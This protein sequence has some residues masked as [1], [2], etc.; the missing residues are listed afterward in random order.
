MTPKE[1]KIFLADWKQRRNSRIAHYQNNEADAAFVGQVIPGNIDGS[2]EPVTDGDEVPDQGHEVPEGEAVPTGQR[3]AGG[4]DSEPV[5]AKV[6]RNGQTES[7]HHISTNDT[8]KPVV[9]DVS[10]LSNLPENQKDSL[11]RLIRNNP[12]LISL[13]ARSLEGKVKLTA[14][15]AAGK[16]D[17]P[18]EV[19]LDDANNKDVLELGNKQ[20][21]ST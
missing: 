2:Y 18:V 15:R 4:D 9:I 6:N 17:G 16:V 11:L 3:K 5:K 19:T 12:K 20:W 10:E 14:F 21:N 8:A 7:P 1:R 13:S